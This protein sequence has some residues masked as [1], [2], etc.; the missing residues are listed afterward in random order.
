MTAP[1]TLAID[2]GGS[3]IK[4]LLLDGQG[5]PI[6]D[7]LRKPTPRPALPSAV[8]QVIQELAIAHGQ[9]HRLAV[10]FPGV[11]RHGITQRAINL[12][13]AWDDFPLQRVLQDMLGVPVR[14]ANDADVQGLGA[15]QGRGVELVI[16]LGTGFGSALF[17][18]GQLVPN[19]EMGQHCFRSRNTYEQC[20]GQAA[21]DRVGVKVW[22]RRLLK[23]IASLQLLFNYDHLYIGGGNAKKITVP[24]PPN[25]T[26]VSN[27]RGL[28]GGIKLWQDETDGKFG[29]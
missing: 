27:D 23:A 19:L 4:S 7:R 11:I 26:V 10:G 28:L 20:L 6:S 16:T 24:L 14:L 8:L 13:P 12:D 22:N 17:V 2:I 18:N 3:G 21:L 25:V 15:I 9:F 1:Y 5:K 29:E